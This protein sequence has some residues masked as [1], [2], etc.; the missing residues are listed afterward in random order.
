M[1]RS[2]ISQILSGERSVSVAAARKLGKC[3][4]LSASSFLPVCEETS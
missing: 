3:F 2:T 1:S 4:G